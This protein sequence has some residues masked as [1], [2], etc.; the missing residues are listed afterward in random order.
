[1]YVCICMYIY[2]IKKVPK[3]KI[4]YIVTLWLCGEIMLLI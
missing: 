3:L 1:M 4:Y 2:V